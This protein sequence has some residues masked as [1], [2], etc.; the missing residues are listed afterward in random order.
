MSVSSHV[1]RLKFGHIPITSVLAL[2]DDKDCAVGKVTAETVVHID[3]RRRD[4]CPAELGVADMKRTDRLI[5]HS[6][7]LHLRCYSMMK[8]ALHS[9]EDVAL[10][11]STPVEGDQQDAGHQ[12]NGYDQRL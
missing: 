11:I 10:Y 1:S 12:G 7:N 3:H 2:D 9:A 5:S 6:H 4:G 8:D